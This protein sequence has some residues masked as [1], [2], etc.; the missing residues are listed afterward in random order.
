MGRDLRKIYTNNTF[1][2]D[3]DAFINVKSTYKIS[4]TIHYYFHILVLLFGKIRHS[5]Y[6]TCRLTKSLHR[7]IFLPVF[8]CRSPWTKIGN[9]MERFVVIQAKIR[10]SHLIKLTM[11]QDPGWLFMPK[12]WHIFSWKKIHPTLTNIQEKTF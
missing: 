3:Y 8:L 1:F 11:L 12:N 6:Q 2:N 5:Q 7:P 10:T 9:K 4:M